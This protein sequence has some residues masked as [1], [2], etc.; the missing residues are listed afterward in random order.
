MDKNFKN[1]LNLF[2]EIKNSNKFYLTG[3]TALSLIYLSHRISFDIDLFT[4]KRYKNKEPN[5]VTQTVEEFIELLKKY[6]YKVKIIR[7]IKQCVEFIVTK[8]KNILKVT[9][10]FDTAKLL[11]KSILKK[12]FKIKVASFEDIA[13][14]K[15]SAFIE[16]L[17]QRDII[18]LYFICKKIDIIKLIKLT[19]KRWDYIDEYQVAITFNKIEPI[20]PNLEPFEGFLIKKLSLKNLYNFYKIKSI[21]ILKSI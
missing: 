6:N 1:I 2:S 15:L 12:E 14:S 10:A 3:A 17:E 7:K 20:V 8:D 11:K 21:E 16:R 5:L 18:D 4:K 9:V 19:K 13:T